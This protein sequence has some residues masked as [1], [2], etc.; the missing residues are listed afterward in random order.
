MVGRRWVGRGLRLPRRTVCNPRELREAAQN[1][2]DRALGPNWLLRKTMSVTRMGES[3]QPVTGS[4]M[5]IVMRISVPPT[6]PHP[7][8]GDKKA[9]Q[10][11]GVLGLFFWHPLELSAR[12]K[13]CSM[14]QI[15]EVCTSAERAWLITPISKAKLQR[16]PLLRSAAFAFN[17]F[18]HAKLMLWR[19]VYKPALAVMGFDV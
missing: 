3:R 6:P 18:S 11:P 15:P 1:P 8:R 12:L 5:W 13:P 19:D 10:E 16:W 2:G 17:E 14:E 7:P 4:S 9:G